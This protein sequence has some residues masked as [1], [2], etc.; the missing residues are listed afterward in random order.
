M[1]TLRDIPYDQ[2]FRQFR[3]MDLFVPGPGANGC[4]IL[5][6]H[7]GGWSGG[8]RGTW[9]AVAEDFCRQG[10]LCASA[11]YRLAPAAIWPAQIED[12]RL[13]MSCFRHEVAQRGASPDK[14]AAVGSSAGGHL[15]AMLATIAPDDLLGAGPHMAPGDT[16]PAAAVC[17]CPVLELRPDRPHS[18]PGIG[19]VSTLLGGP[20]S[21]MPEVYEAASPI[22]RVTGAEPPLLLL[23][24]DADETVPPAQSALM[25]DAMRSAGGG[26]E[27]VLMPGVEHGFGYGVTTDPQIEA[28][29]HVRRFLAARF[30][31]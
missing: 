13:A 1:E 28:I 18:C 24:G 20:E 23:H 10:Y 30:R 5:F 17:Y 6:I 19:M 15:V 11:D 12:V 26:A 8:G 2:E 22:A 31:L 3:T 25:C 7:G 4:A 29:E 14:I 16:R 27:L 9:S 21:A